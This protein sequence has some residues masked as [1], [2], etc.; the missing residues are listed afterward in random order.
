MIT[1]KVDNKT[2]HIFNEEI[3][4]VKKVP[5]II[6]NNFQG[7]GKELY[8]EC[9]KMNCNDFILVN[10]SSL[11]WNDEMTPWECLPLYN[12]DIGY[13]GKAN[14]YVLELT[15]DIIPQIEQILKYKP[16]YYGIVGYSLGGLFA[17][18]SLYKTDIFTRF[19]SASGSL[20]YPNFLNFIKNNPF[21]IK[22]ERMYLSLGNK[23]KNTK[24]ETLKMVQDNLEEIFEFYKSKGLN[25]YY[26]LNSGGHFKDCYLRL[27]KGIKWI[28]SKKNK[29][30]YLIWIL[31]K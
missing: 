4:S 28:L 16:V 25:V 29:G 1:F 30:D 11:N 7:N 12:G 26:E 6:H 23:E 20:W 22:P 13:K 5:I 10:I 27:A 8:E 18:Y 19:V 15:T 24:N 31:K 21:M 17:I 9:K 3:I 2:I 14:Q